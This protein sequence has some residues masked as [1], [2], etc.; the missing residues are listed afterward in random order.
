MSEDIHEMTPEELAERKAAVK[1]TRA[2][3]YCDQP[4][5]VV[6]LGQSPF[7]DWDAPEAWFCVNENCGYRVMS[8]RVM[9]AQGIPGGSYRFIYIPA[10]DWCGPI[11]DTRASLLQDRPAD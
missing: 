9:E 7:N 3:P 8:R 2:C 4:L 6:D 1:H 11:A 5:H 10:R